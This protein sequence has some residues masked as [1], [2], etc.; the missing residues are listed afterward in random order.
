MKIIAKEEY[1]FKWV[2]IWVGDFE[3]HDELQARAEAVLMPEVDVAEH[4]VRPYL[5]SAEPKLA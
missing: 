2:S 1:E 5:W 4:G 3:S